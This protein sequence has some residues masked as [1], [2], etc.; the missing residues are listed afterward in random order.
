MHTLKTK[1]TA[2][3]LGLALALAL[4]GLAGATDLTSFKTVF[5]TDFTSA[6]YGG[7]PSIGTGTIALSGVSGAVTEAYLFWQG[8]NDSTD[9]NANASVNFNGTDIAPSLAYPATTA[10]ASP[11]AWPTAPM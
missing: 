5:N 6:G 1:K 9:N 3:T 2:I 4:P 8:P 7:M 11:T 10:G